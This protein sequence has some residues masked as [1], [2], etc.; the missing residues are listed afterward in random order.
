MK[1]KYIAIIIPV[2]HAD[3]SEEEAISLTQCMKVLSEYQIIIIKP[4]G[5]NIDRILSEYP[6]L[7]VELFPDNCFS[8]LR[9]Y[10]KM[11]L[12]ESFYRRF[13]QYQYVLIYQLDAYVF[14]DELLCWA[15]KG[16]DYIGAPWVPSSSSLLT[17]YGRFILFFK[18][19]MYTVLG[20]E[21]RKSKKYRNYQIGN[22]GLSLRKVS[23]MIEIT[24]FYKSK[25][26]LYLDDNK[27]FYPEDVFLLLELNSR[28]HRLYKPRFAEA[29]K[30]SVEENPE[31][32]YHYNGDRLPF[33]CHA[34]SHKSY[35]NFWI[36][37]IK[38]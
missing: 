25:I 24:H 33:G 21:K 35:Q 32:A 28:G 30:F 7:T 11:V 3:L 5:L 6:S 29:L 38:K 27:I 36:P 4:V 23:K 34:W 22:G 16:Y 18:R 8:N 9:A 15:S 20:N 1:K 2:Y 19:V 17:G 31:W 10:N 12:E 26:D 13:S 37:I 14:K